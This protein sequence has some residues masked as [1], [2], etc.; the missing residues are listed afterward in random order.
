M[1]N[2]NT[3]KNNKIKL[4]SNFLMGVV[5]INVKNLQLQ[6]NFYNKSLNLDIIDENSQKVVLGN[7]NKPLL[8]LHREDSLS[9]S[10]AGDAGLYHFAVVYSSRGDL[11]RTVYRILKDESHYFTGSA[12]HL[13]SEA[14]YFSDPEG[15]G[16]ELYYDRDQ[17]TWKWENGRVQM[18]ALY[19]DPE[20]YI[21]RYIVLEEKNT[22]TKIGHIHLKVGDIERAKEFYV[23]TLGFEITAEMPQALFISVGGYHHHIGMNT[24]ESY[25]ATE[26]NESHGLKIFEFIFSDIREIE[27]VKERLNDNHIHYSEDKKSV[28]FEDPWKNKIRIVYSSI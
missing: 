7:N 13:V 12:D 26:R 21:S 18:A 24:W 9:Q 16:I 23:Y 27:S 10:Q 1:Q 14:F 6:K 28:E 2:Q 20:E 19:I 15:N 25:G 3:T 22:E 11:A 5:E 4:S 8:I 17:D